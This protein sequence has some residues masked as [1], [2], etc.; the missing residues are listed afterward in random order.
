M[1]EQGQTNPRPDDPWQIDPADFPGNESLQAQ[2]QFLLNYAVLAPSGHNTQPWLFRLGSDY[3]DVLAD[4]TR[5]L[6]VVDPRDREL[7]ISC[8]A[9]TETFALAAQKFGFEATVTTLP[10]GSASDTV[11][12]VHLRG[13]CAQAPPRAALDAIVNRRTTRASFGPDS[14]PTDLRRACITAAADTG[15]SVLFVEDAAAREAIADLVAE[16]DRIQF[17][18]PEF[19]KELGAWIRTRNADRRDGMSGAA[20]GMPD[21]LSGLGSLMIRTFDI[22]GTTAS[23]DARKI[24][25]GSP[26]LA[27][28][29]T[30]KDGPSDWVAAGRALVQVLT[31]LSA[32]GWT[33]SYLNQPIEVSDLRPQLTTTL[34][35]SEHPQLLLRIGQADLPPPAVRRSITEVLTT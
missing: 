16:G 13:T 29:A 6:K 23:R 2:I 26:V 4:R 14:L 11:A 34:G 17:G 9:A 15:T 31:T 1:P 27:I 30:P 20:F 19:R 22:G 24:R 28:L 21:M 18:D 7:I 35:T 8:A 25:E 33:A 5:R 32:N 10:D 12:Q 3:I